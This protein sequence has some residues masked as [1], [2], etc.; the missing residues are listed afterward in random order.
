[1][2]TANNYVFQPLT[3]HRQVVHPMES[4]QPIFIGCTTWWWPVRGRNM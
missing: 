4:P 1:M 2:V 3:S